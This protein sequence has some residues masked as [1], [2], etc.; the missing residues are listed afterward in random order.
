MSL[1]KINLFFKALGAFIVKNRIALLL[2][3]AL[4]SVLGISG[5]PKLHV[6][7]NDSAWLADSERQKRKN[8]EFERLFGNNETV[9]LLVEAEDVFHPGVLKL[10]EDMSAE[11]LEKVSYADTITSIL[12]ADVTVGTE[13]GLEILHPF[14]DGIPE[15]AS[16]IQKAKELMLSRDSIKDKLVSADA[17]ET[18]VILSFAPFPEESEWKKT[19]DVDPLYTTGNEAIAVV[20]DPKWQTG[21]CTVKAAGLPY[22]EAEERVVSKKEAGRSIMLG[23][24]AMVVLLI[25]FLR[26]IRGTLVPIAATGL[27]IT[28]VF[29]IMAYFGIRADSNMITLPVMLAMALS[30]GYSV[31]LFSSFRRYFYMH[32]K[33]KQAVIESVENTGWALLFTVITTVGSLLS[34]LT[35]GL[36]SVRWVGSACAATV[37]AVYI[38]VSILIPILLSFGKDT[39]P[40]K[41][42]AAARSKTTDEKF[43]RFG[44]LVLKRRKPVLIIFSIITA[45]LIPSVFFISVNMDSFNFMGTRIPY[46]KRLY[47]I[48]HSQ[49]GSYFNYNIMISFEDTDAVKNP[50]V[51]KNLDILLNETGE[52][53]SVKKIAG[54][55]K[56]FSVLDIV[57]EMNKSLHAD[58]PAYYTV[59]DDADLLNQLLFLYEISGGDHTRWV[60]DEFSILRATVELK[61]FNANQLVESIKQTEK[62]AAEL[63]P[64]GD[65]FL[66][67]PAVQFAEM[68]KII[69]YGEIKSFL[70]SLIVIALFMTLVFASIKMG[71]I[72]LIPNIM[73]LIVISA[74]MGYLK[75]PL[76]VITM[77]IIPMLLG[78]AVDDT[79]HFTNHVKFEFEKTGSYRKAI[80][81]TFNSIG[82]T[83]AM[84]TVILSVSFGMYMTCLID[85]IARLGF[86]CVIGLLAAL[87]ADYTM[88][89]I[90]IYITKPFGAEREK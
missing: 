12:T 23:F 1:V 68:N 4:V 70:S 81:N 60:N 79:I 48:T 15:D 43:E 7:S 84:T 54:K 90:L 85:A 14:E 47:E 65:C 82:K 52:H 5:L 51:L 74:F 87:I 29:G 64:D 73:P 88:T 10:I 16:A 59:P 71:L 31:H 41:I 76:D 39:Q 22:T 57:K 20:T 3:L 25:V 33:R 62:R 26:S 18:W 89:P 2:A 77:T 53:E 42:K 56:I 34:L 38:Y 17:K 58:N 63:F 49:L 6:E 37:F 75:F 36:T 83:L 32:G 13:E 24:I 45:L 11:L 66:V 78:I 8:E 69:V 44:S 50:E 9:V 27:G 67:G 28:T 21:L 55:P 61:S 72:G 86:L 35:T 80:C 30:V 40:E 19:G 46:T